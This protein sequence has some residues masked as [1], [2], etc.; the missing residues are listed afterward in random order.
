MGR[1]GRWAL[2]LQS[3][4]RPYLYG[5]KFVII[6]GHNPLRWLR[7]IKDPMGR[8]GR[9][10]L[11][12]QSYDFEIRHRAGKQHGN[13][14]DLSR[15]P[16]TGSAQEETEVIVVNAL[17]D[18][19]LD[20]NAV[21]TLQRRDELLGPLIVYMQTRELP[22]SNAKARQL[23]AMA[24]NYVLENDI[25]YHLQ[26]PPARFRSEPFRKQLIIIYIIYT[27]GIPSAKTLKYISIKNRY[28]KIQWMG[29]IFQGVVF[30]FN[31][32]PQMYLEVFFELL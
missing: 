28:I 8:L 25:L 31:S 24:D 22:E 20:L 19:D 6:T 32:A 29:L 11:S 10:A 9:W 5:R 27:R 7:N 4:F 3:Y 1:L 30:E 13:A 16:K 26:K 2:S 17:H 12:L 21:K 18:Y 14:D 15:K 23:V